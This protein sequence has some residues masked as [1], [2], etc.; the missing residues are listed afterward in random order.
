MTTRAIRTTDAAASCDVC[1]RTLLR[2]EHAE[3]CLD[4]G[5]RRSV[6]ELCTTR[7]RHEGWIRQGTTP[8]DAPEDTG[9]ERRRSVLSPLLSRLR[10]R[11]R[12][13]AVAAPNAPAAYEPAP[14]EPVPYEPV[15]YERI[16]Y[17]PVPY[18]PVPEAHEVHAWR[19]APAAPPP[20]AP[21]GRVRT[22]VREPRH[23]RAVPV[24]AEH[25]IAW[26]LE[27][28]NSSEHRRTIA[29]VSRSLGLPTVSVQPSAARVS[30][31]GVVVSWELCW[32][33][34]QV[35]LGDEPSVC[36]SDRGYELDELS[37][38]QRTPNAVAD[39]TAN[40]SA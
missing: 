14:N 33:H 28:F 11:R 24:R 35:D 10:G 30:V 20:P 19:Q 16:A 13:P 29:G 40:L 38:E 18:E 32:Y 1:G 4:G 9:Y 8:P 12:R 31:V 27:L 21:R 15:P 37:A 36:L 5:A 2:G 26:A 22:P 34:Y 17:E 39:E 3:V 6:C 7:A 25:K 23:V